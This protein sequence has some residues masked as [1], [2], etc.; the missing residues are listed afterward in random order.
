MNLQKIY[1]SKTIYT[2]LNEKLKGSQ[3]LLVAGGHTVINLK[4]RNYVSNEVITS[5]KF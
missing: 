4:D 2:F 5:V 1:Y 3:K